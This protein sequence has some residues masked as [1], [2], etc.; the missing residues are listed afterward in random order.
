MT[1]S[2]RHLLIP[3]LFLFGI[4]MLLAA[5]VEAPT[6][7]S[8]PIEYQAAPTGEEAIETTPLPEPDDDLI[9]SQEE[10]E[11]DPPATKEDPR[12]TGRIAFINQNGQLIV[13]EADKHLVYVLTPVPR[14]AGDTNC[15]EQVNVRDLL[16]VINGWGPCAGCPSD[17]NSDQVVNIDDLMLVIEH[18]TYN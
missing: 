4:V 6:S 16:N 14:K 3:L 10:P 7:P 12:P 2:N 15:D 18:W 1:G 11:P 8:S 17:L 9:E 5:C 13:T